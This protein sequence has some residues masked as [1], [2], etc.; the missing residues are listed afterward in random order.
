M[1]ECHLLLTNQI[2]LV[3]LE[4]NLVVPD[5]SKSLPLGGPPGQVT[6]QPQHFFNKVLEYLVSSDKERRNALLISKLKASY[7]PDFG[8]EELI[9]SLW[10]KSECEYDISA[11]Y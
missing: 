9:S 6:I 1:E 10:I 8:L 2:D 11:A 4:G 7:Y 3:N 5:V